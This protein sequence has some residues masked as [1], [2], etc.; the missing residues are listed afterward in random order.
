MERLV[1]PKERLGAAIGPS[2][3][4]K[5]EIERRTGTKLTFDSETGE[6]LIELVG[7]SPLG[8]LQARDL[9]SAVARGFSPERAFSLLEENR[10]L[11]VIDISDYAGRSEGAI[12][13]LKGRVIGEAGKTRKTIEQMTGTHVSVY[14]KTIALIGTPEQLEVAKGAVGMLLRGSPHSAVYRFLERKRPELRRAITGR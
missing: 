10:Y 8:A 13:R 7:E 1:L 2:G 14:G 5:S 11:E 12:R 6:V 3:S 4:I 9:L